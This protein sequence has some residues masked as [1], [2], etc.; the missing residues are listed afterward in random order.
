MGGEE[1]LYLGEEPHQLWQGAVLKL[2]MQM[3]ISLI[4]DDNS[5]DTL[6]L[7]IPTARQISIAQDRAK[8][9]KQSTLTC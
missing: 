8:Q 9:A 7:N 2:K 3:Q 6:N 4:D 1:K 5:F